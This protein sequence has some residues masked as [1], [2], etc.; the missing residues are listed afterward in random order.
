MDIVSIMPFERML[1]FHVGQSSWSFWSQVGMCHQNSFPF[2]ILT[3]QPL[4]VIS[5]WFWA[6]DICRNSIPLFDW[7]SF[8]LLWTNGIRIFFDFKQCKT[9][10]ESAH[11]VFQWISSCKLCVMKLILLVPL[12]TASS[13]SLGNDV[14]FSG[15]VLDLLNIRLVIVWQ[16]S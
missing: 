14:P 3:V 11:K 9:H 5:G 2:S 6:V 4:D 15:T 8:I 10:C 1:T 16:F 12:M 7:I 13:S